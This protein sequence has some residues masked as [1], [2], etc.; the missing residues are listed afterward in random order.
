MIYLDFLTGG[1]SYCYIHHTFLLG[2]SNGLV[3][4]HASGGLFRKVFV[5]KRIDK[6]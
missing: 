3:I 2:V 1:K 5:M 6:I 4:N